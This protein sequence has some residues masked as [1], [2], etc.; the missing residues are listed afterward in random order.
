MKLI[1]VMILL[2]LKDTITGFKE[3]VEGK[4][5]NKP[6]SAFYMKGNISEV[7]E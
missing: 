1:M 6:E 3:I 2:K 4:H 7:K 5:D